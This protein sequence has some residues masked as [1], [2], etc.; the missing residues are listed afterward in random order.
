MKYDFSQKE[1]EQCWEKIVLAFGLALRAGK[2]SVGGE[3]CVESIRSDNAKLVIVPHDISYNTE[4]RISNS[5]SYHDTPLLH[6]PCSKSTLA[7]KFGKSSE[8]SCAAITD[9]GFVK[10]I[11]KLYGEI[12]TTHTEV[13]Q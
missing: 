12:H 4:K 1:L 2:C 3:K 6:L 7:E 5:A 13:Q 11:D 9:D 10:I 8:I